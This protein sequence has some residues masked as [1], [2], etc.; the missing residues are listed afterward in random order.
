M[1]RRRP[2]RSVLAAATAI[3]LTSTSAVALTVAG[4]AAALVATPAPA[5]AWDNGLARTPPMGFNNWNSTACR[6]EFN[7]T[8][9]RGIADIFV[10]RGLRDAGY[11][12]VNIDDC[13]AQPQR[14][15]RGNLVPLPARFP[16]GMNALA[17]YIHGRGLKFGI[18]TSAGTLTCNRDGRF[19]G[20]IGHERQDAAQFAA[21][22]VDYI[23]YDNC[24]DHQGMDART[25]YG[26]MHD[27]LASIDRPIVYSICEWG[28]AEPKVWT[29]AEPVGNLWRTTDDIKANWGSIMHNLHI[30]E[31]LAQYAGP[32][33]WNDPD[34]LEVGNGS[35]TA[36]EQRSHFSLWAMM[37]APLLIGTDLRRASQQTI[38]IL[39]NRDII[40]VDQDPLGRQGTLVKRSNGLAVYTKPLADGDR[41]VALFNES[42]ATADDQH[43]RCRDRPARVVV[44]QPV[45][46]LEQGA[47]YHHRVHQRLGSRARH[48][49]IPGDAGHRA[50]AGQPVRG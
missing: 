6:A 36:T 20:A 23:K 48:R 26:R 25:R 16:S 41:A 18:Y 22:G 2:L 35:L 1:P 32:G 10:N 14:D 33:H 30:N 21:W 11:Q 27:A 50:R 9:I 49:R 28:Q 17:D 15:S 12:Y 46:P 43:D 44:V 8:M 39:T 34:M 7:E 45:R 42:A 24:G 4:V 13:W 5:S 29:W 19:P 37:A 47:A 31:N 3:A 38:D 40:A